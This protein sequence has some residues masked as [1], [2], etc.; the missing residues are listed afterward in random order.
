MWFLNVNEHLPLT[1]ACMGSG[2]EFAETSQVQT[3]F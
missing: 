1:V 2:G 3:D